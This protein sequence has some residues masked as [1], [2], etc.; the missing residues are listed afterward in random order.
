[1]LASKTIVGHPKGRANVVLW[2]PPWPLQ[3]YAIGGAFLDGE[4][5]VI[6]VLMGSFAMAVVLAAE[7]GA[8]VVLCGSLAVEQPLEDAQAIEWAL[9]GDL[10]VNGEKA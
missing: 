4:L 7:V 2:E 5:V 9:D 1:M 6:P 10:Y 3:G 8:E